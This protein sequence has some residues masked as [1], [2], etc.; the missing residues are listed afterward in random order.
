M[1]LLLSIE[2]STPVC[3]VA[4]TRNEDILSYKEA[5]GKLSHAARLTVLIEEVMKETAISYSSLDAVVVSKGPGSYTG[6][7]IGVSAA[8]GICYGADIPLIAIN[9]LEVLFYSLFKQSNPIFDDKTLFCPMIDARRMEV[10]TAMFDKN[11]S[12]VM[13]TQALIIQEDSFSNYLKTNKVVFFGDG[14]NKCM[15]VINNN[16]AQFIENIY[17]MAS[18]MQIKAISEFKK[19]LFED[20]A[21]FEPFYLKDFV[22]TTPKARI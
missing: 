16:N 11:G 12:N 10:Y 22:A 7:R 19:Q 20:V 21:Y 1:S 4:L 14:A 13:E 17:P 3:S 18:V 6:L 8:K 15:P 2:T 9:S 5:P